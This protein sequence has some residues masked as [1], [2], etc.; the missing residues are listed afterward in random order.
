[1]D[2]NTFGRFFGFICV[3]TSTPLGWGVGVS[4]FTKLFFLLTSILLS[5]ISGQLVML[6]ST[7]PAKGPSGW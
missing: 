4:V 1:M 2:A 7:L 3:A 5:G 6:S